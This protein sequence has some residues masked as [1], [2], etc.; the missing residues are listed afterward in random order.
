MAARTMPP[1]RADHVGSLLRPRALLQARQDH[2]AGRIDADE[3]RA[4]EDDAIRQVVADQHSVGLRSAT[5]GEFRRAS[6]H[7][8]FIYQL[9][10]IEKVTDHTLKVQFHNE[11]GDIEFAPPSLHVD[12]PIAL[13]HTIF[14]DAFTF[15]RET[16]GPGRSSRS[17]TG[18]NRRHR[19][20]RVGRGTNARTGRARPRP[21][22]SATAF[23]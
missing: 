18:P 20:G 8:D 2:A 1:F 12:A 5:D 22:A 23:R 4:I 15:L 13:E 10:G 19:G 9:G 17:P 3:L 14:G 11:Q 7:M 21:A 16:A 6:W